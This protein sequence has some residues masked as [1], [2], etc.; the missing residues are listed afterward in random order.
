[1]KAI[2]ITTDE[3]LQQAFALR[4]EVFV[5]E[6]GVPDEAEL[7]E[8]DTLQAATHVL[9]YNDGAIALATGRFRQKGEFGKVERVC[10]SKAA[11]GLGL[12]TVIMQKIEELAKEQGF[13][14]LKLH[15]QT[16]AE[17]FYLQLGYE[18][19]SEQFF[20]EGIPHVEMT[21]VLL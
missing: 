9:I 11:R 14:T 16:H 10:V 17:N 2:K 7:D 15:G 12:G 20:E 18:T 3:Q 6:Q 1:M 4:K 8:F 19:T 13:T 21:K 5:A